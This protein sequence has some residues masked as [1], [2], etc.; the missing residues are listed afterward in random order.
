MVSNLCSHER[1]WLSIFIDRQWSAGEL[2]N[3]SLCQRPPGQDPAS[4]VLSKGCPS[5]E[6]GGTAI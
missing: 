4:A 1:T 6:K 5:I 3:G 2:Q